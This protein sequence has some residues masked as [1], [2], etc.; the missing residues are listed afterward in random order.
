MAYKEAAEECF[1]RRMVLLSFDNTRERNFFTN[2][3]SKTFFESG[4]DFH[5]YM[6][7]KT[8]RQ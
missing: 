1:A 7:I 3:L 6:S 8:K 5:N 2:K 4:E